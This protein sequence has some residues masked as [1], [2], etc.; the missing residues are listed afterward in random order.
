[1][2]RLFLVVACLM[3]AACTTTQAKL[4]PSTGITPPAG[5]RILIV[6][7]DVQ[8]GVLT[9]S[10]LVETRQDWSEQGRDN[11]VGQYRQVFDAKSHAYTVLEPSTAQAGQVGQMLRLHQAVG[12]S[13]LLFQTSGLYALPTHPASTFEWT[14][15]DGAKSLAD[16]YH[17][18][19]ALF[20]RAVGSY[21]SGGR[22]AMMIGMAALGVSVPLGGQQMYVSLVD[23]H[24]GR[25]IWFNYA[26]AGPNADMR[27]PAGAASLVTDLM[28]T[29]PL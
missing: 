15:G 3:M 2:K 4:S 11:L 27:S 5:A 10:G 21:A 18:D 23:L 12:E 26:V 29:A 13:I 9:A 24:T 28:K 7:P 20:S 17:A 6:Q 22:V 14:L 19:Y 25:V 1:M 8:L 16:T